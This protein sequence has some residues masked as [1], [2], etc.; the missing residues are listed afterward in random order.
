MKVHELMN[1]AVGERYRV[2]FHLRFYMTNRPTV[3]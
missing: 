1:T 2:M 3:Q